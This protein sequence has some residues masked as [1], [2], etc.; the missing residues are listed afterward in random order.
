MLSAVWNG[1]LAGSPYTD[2]Y[3]SVWSLWATESW[4]GTWHNGWFNHPQGQAWSPSTLFWGTAIIPFKDLV[5]IE[6]LYNLCLFMNRLLTCWAFYL[7]GRSWNNSHHN[8]LLW[9]VIIGM[10]PM[11]HG[12]AVEGIFEGTQLWPLGFWLWSIKK[13]R[14]TQSVLFGSIVII[15]NWYW[16]LCWGILSIILGI[17]ERKVWRTMCLSIGLS[18]PWIVHFVHIQEA[19]TKLDAHIYQAMGLSLT[20]PTPNILTTPNP[21][22][23]SNY[24]GWTVCA[25]LLFTLWQRTTSIGWGILGL[26]LMLSMG[27]PFLQDLPIIGSMR[28]PYRMHLLTLVGVCIVLTNKKHSWSHYWLILIPLE[29]LF[30]SPIDWKLPSAP[31]KAPSYVDVIDGVV[32]E[33]PGPLQRAPG[34]IDPSRPRSKY[35][36]YYQTFHQQPS[37]WTLG[38]NGLV[39]PN[40]CFQGTR[41]IDPHATKSEQKQS[42]KKE[43]WNDI[44]WVVIHNTNP[45]L[46]EWLHTLGFEQK[47]DTP[48]LLWHRITKPFNDSQMLQQRPRL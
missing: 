3:P 43:C 10:N 12:F 47:T 7:V 30:L 25:W 34:D 36:Q 45:R 4:W 41:R 31:S 9:M 1:D 38:F 2:L 44:E 6:S 16:A 23:M 21:F 15:S 5:P 35:L 27:F 19:S 14:W 33:L 28:F 29:F 13:Q 32:L 40:D 37:P 17:Q 46:N 8:G 18:M 48:P 42:L 22:A 24:T 11:I 26:G 39:E 20:I